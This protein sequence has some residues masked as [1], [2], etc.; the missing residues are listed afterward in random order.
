[1]LEAMKIEENTSVSRNMID[2]ETIP[3][4]RQSVEFMLM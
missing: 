4:R 2:V 3:L 1:M